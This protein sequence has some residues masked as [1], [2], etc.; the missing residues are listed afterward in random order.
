MATQW[1]CQAVSDCFDQWHVRCPRGGGRFAAVCWLPW[2]ASAARDHP[3][4]PTGLPTGRN[5]RQ[6]FPILCRARVHFGGPARFWWHRDCHCHGCH[7][8]TIRSPSW[9]FIAPQRPRRVGVLGPTTA[10]RR[11]DRCLGEPAIGTGPDNRKGLRAWYSV[12]RP[13]RAPMQIRGRLRLACQ[14]S[15][16]M[17]IPAPGEPALSHPACDASAA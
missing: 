14:G 4:R 2:S 17:D 8:S 7:P 10:L 3:E 12:S 1:S 13:A 6:N 5:L 9:S 16:L 15:V 11:A